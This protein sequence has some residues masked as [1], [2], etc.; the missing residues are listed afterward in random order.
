M[1]NPAGLAD[2][3]IDHAVA[4]APTTG[5]AKAAT[6]TLD[7]F[8]RS[9]L[10]LY[11]SDRNQP[12]KDATSGLSPYLH[13]GHI[14]T[15]Q[16]FRELTAQCG[17]TPDNIADKATGSSEGLV[18]CEPGSRIV[19]GRAD[20]LARSRLQHVLAARTTTTNTNRCPT[21]PGRR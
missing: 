4:A 6:R 1:K 10:S 15:H 8:L 19:S 12:E 18:G 2:F 11:E 21:G 5:G 7:A 14:S 16:V 20:H 9:K 3:P 17:W 13:F